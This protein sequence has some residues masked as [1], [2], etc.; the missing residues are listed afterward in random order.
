MRTLVVRSGP[1]PRPVPWWTG[2]PAR[3]DDRRGGLH[4]GSR[5]SRPSTGQRPAT[6]C[7]PLGGPGASV[8]SP[9]PAYCG[10]AS[11]RPGPEEADCSL[12]D[13][14]A[15]CDFSVVRVSTQPG[16][17]QRQGVGHRGNVVESDPEQVKGGLGRVVPNKSAAQ[18]NGAA[19]DDLC[20]LQGRRGMACP[21]SSTATVRSGR[22]LHQ[23]NW[24]DR[25][26]SPA[27]SPTDG[28]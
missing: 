9:S 14:D 8:A 17:P 4:T 1:R 28:V 11:V 2:A 3:P 26:P 21:R 12:E 27:G 19:P 24:H 25:P 22:S 20:P 7:H 23:V 16:A 6:P 10:I 5:D 18:L 13:V 15:A